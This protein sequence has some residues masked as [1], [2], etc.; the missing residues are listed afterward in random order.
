MKYGEVSREIIIAEQEKL[1]KE[2]ITANPKCVKKTLTDK[3]PELT[4][5]LK[6]KIE[7]IRK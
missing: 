5:L 3:F 1:L 7:D 2:Y 4:Y 6:M